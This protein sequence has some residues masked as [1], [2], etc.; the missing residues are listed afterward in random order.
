MPVDTD[1]MLSV[2]SQNVRQGNDGTGKNIADR[3]VRLKQL[4]EDYDPD[5][6]GAQEVTKEW[7]GIL[8]EYFGDEYGIIGCSRDGETAETG[9]WTPILYRKDRFTLLDS[10]TFWLTDTPNEV[11]KIDGIKY[12]RICTWALLL[13]KVTDTEVLYCNTH[14]DHQ[15]DE[16]RSQQ[17]KYLIN[18]LK[19]YEDKYPIFLTGDFNATAGTTPYRTITSVLSD[20]HRKASAD[21]SEVKGTFHDYLAPK[22][23]IDF[24]F[25][26]DEKADAVAYRIQSD[27][28]KGYV[29]DHYGVIAYFKYK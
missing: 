29:S 14:L 23:E 27:D 22:Q 25:Y 10:G 17:A 7:L 21:A 19:K 2:M 24:C 28:Y 8:K 4:V 9:E 6:W 12:N 11:S 16:A 3:K 15:S 13:D 26:D 5:L 18:F 20:A 1:T